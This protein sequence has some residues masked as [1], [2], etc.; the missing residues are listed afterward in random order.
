MVNRIFSEYRSQSKI[1]QVERKSFLG[2]A[3]SSLQVVVELGATDADLLSLPFF[4]EACL[5]DVHSTKQGDISWDELESK[6]HI[7][8]MMKKAADAL[9]GMETMLM[10][11]P[12]ELEAIPLPEGG[13]PM[14]CSGYEGANP[15]TPQE[16]L[17]AT[18][19]TTEASDVMDDIMQQ[20][21]ELN[22]DELHA[23][24]GLMQGVTWAHK[25]L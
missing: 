14:A 5:R 8:R 17:Q 13:V 10:Q 15:E 12:A 7:N 22:L 18:N 9:K 24:K 20:L 3:V 6:P 11:S 16:A 25:R 19:S 23:V 4:G 2:M 1:K 21:G